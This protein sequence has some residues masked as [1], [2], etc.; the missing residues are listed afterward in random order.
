MKEVISH[1]LGTSF[2]VLKTEANYN[3]QVGL[4][5]ML[6]GLKDEHE[7]AVLEIGTNHPGEIA[8][9]TKAAEPTHGII[10][11]IGREHL[12][13]FK[14]LKGVAKEELTLFRHLEKA[15]GFVFIN[16]DDTFLAK[17]K[18]NFFG[19]NISFG[20]NLKSDVSAKPWFYS[21]GR[22]TKSRN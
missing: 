16:E 5:R 20:K 15:K 4:P 21:V 3:N 14:N 17:E 9:L 8:W 7:I 19:R 10:T 13:F 2:K 11:N 12:E 1:V 18:K 22:K 6:F